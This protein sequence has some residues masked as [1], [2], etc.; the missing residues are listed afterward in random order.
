MTV[1]VFVWKPVW[2]DDSDGHASMFIHFYKPHKKKYI[3]WW[4]KGEMDLDGE[5]PAWGTKGTPRRTFHNDCIGEGNGKVRKPDWALT[6]DGLDEDRIDRFWEELHKHRYK[7][8]VYKFNCSSVVYHALRA[9]GATQT[10]S[11]PVRP[12]NIIDYCEKLKNLLR[13]SRHERPT[14]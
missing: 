4:P 7:W 13:H 2:R 12:L 14:D 3:S 6:L 8:D 5:A 9:G 11:D 1:A 10:I